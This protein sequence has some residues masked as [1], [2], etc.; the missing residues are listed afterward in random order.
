[1]T[2]GSDCAS[3]SRVTLV[4]PM[5][6]SDIEWAARKAGEANA[7]LMSLTSEYEDEIIDETRR[8]LTES[9]NSKSPKLWGLVATRQSDPSE[10]IRAG[11]VCLNK[12]DTD[13]ETLDI[14]SLFT[15][16]EFRR[17]GVGAALLKGCV[18]KAIEEGYTK[19]TLTTNP[20]WA[21]TIR[22]YERLGFVK[23]GEREE[24]MFGLD[25]VWAEYTKWL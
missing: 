19:L 18:L 8:Q 4:R 17:L 9:H 11:F 12:V 16:P 20:A 1:M 15:L 3:S 13:A 22:L 5:N 25:G 24:K 6:E 10:S 23:T 2:E 21:N 14:D 7:T